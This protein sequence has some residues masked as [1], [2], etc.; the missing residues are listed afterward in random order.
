MGPVTP[1]EDRFS[2]A[3][4]AAFVQ[5]YGDAWRSRDPGRILAECSADVVWSVP[6]VDGPL[7]GTDEVRRWLTD[8]FTML[9][10]AT[11]DYPLGAPYL[12]VDGRGAAARFRVRGI[13]RGPMV[14]PGFAPTDGPV[15]DEGVEF[16]EAFEAGRLARCT[17]VFDG[18]H[19]AR[20]IG[21]VP[22]PGTRAERFGVLLQHAE[23]RRRRRAARR[24]GS[25]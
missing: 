18:L 10:E 8:F 13:M 20:Q 4:L 16:Y 22:P 1:V 25:G 24:N 14:P 6:G 21:A 11:F 23:A 15:E 7:R 2:E 5:R 12:A 17:I 19:V 3:T 9:P